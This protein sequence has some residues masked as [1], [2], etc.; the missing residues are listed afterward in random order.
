MTAWTVLAT[1]GPGA[2]VGLWMLRNT[3]HADRRPI[4]VPPPIT[5]TYVDHQI[6]LL[7]QQWERQR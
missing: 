3:N 7:E 5:D 2:L 6:H 4:Y 1:C